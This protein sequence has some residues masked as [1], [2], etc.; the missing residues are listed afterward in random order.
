MCSPIFSDRKI[1][2]FF[3]SITWFSGFFQIIGLLRTILR[4]VRLL[5]LIGLFLYSSM[6]FQS[7]YQFVR[8]LG[9]IG[10]LLYIFLTNSVFILSPILRL[11]PL[12]LST[13]TL[14]NF[15]KVRIFL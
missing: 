1:F 4:V 3:L 15:P 11:P 5:G 13:Q 12:S 9:L 8:L 14:N 2:T 10:L 6:R 7:I